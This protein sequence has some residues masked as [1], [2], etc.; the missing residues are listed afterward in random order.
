VLR[1]PLCFVSDL[2]CFLRR[3]IID[4]GLNCATKEEEPKNGF[5]VVDDFLSEVLG[6]PQGEH[7]YE[8]LR[9]GLLRNAAEDEEGKW[10]LKLQTE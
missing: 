7:P 10:R 3:Y 9:A 4:K 8:E 6:L 2:M 1:Q 5:F